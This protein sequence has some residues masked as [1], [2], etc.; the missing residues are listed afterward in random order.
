M[1]DQAVSGALERAVREAVE[2]RRDE[3]VE[4]TRELVRRQTTLGAEEPAQVLVDER[5]RAVGFAVERVQPDGDAA[6]ADPYAGYPYLSYEGRSCVAARLAGSGGGRSLHLSGHLDIV[7]VERPDLWRHEPWSAEVAEGRIWGRGAGD[8]KGGL[9]AYLIA[10]SVVA[11]VCDDRRGDLVFSSVIEE[12][13]G[14]NG[15]WSVLRAGYGADAVLIGE[16]TALRLGHA[17][18]GVVWARLSAAGGAGHAMLAGGDGP[19]DRLCRAV[20][21]LRRVE[22]EIN[23]PVRDPVFA[24]VRERPY[25]MTIGKIG[26]GVWTASTPHELVANVRFGFGRDLEPAEVQARLWEVVREAS[27]EV[28][29]QFE[30]FRARAYCHPTSGPLFD[31]LSAAHQA[32]IG[33]EAET[34]AFTAT[35]DARYVEGACLCYGPVAGNLHGTDEWVDVETL[36]QTATVVALTAAEWTA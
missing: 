12:E 22:A 33:S 6:R 32:I 34:V 8:M 21:G 27:P 16:S 29:I 13:C 19:F 36:V 2:R 30:A 5:L 31:S 24:A 9:A 20:A 7:P 3:L 10:A 15:M 23:E 11:E 14:G 28:E 35:T 17:G 4:L 26:G 25:G 1:T 18:T